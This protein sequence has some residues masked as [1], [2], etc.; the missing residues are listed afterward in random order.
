[1]FYS[2]N[3]AGSERNVSRSTDV[4]VKLPPDH[5]VNVEMDIEDKYRVQ[6]SGIDAM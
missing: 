2:E 1:V 6:F 4:S 5:G 3:N